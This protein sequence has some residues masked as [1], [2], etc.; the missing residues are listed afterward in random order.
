MR[1]DV[2][3]LANETHTKLTIHRDPL[4]R[5]EWRMLACMRILV[6]EDDTATAHDI[7]AAISQARH[8]ALAV[9]SAEHARMLINTEPF[10]LAVVD[11]GLPGMNGFGLV[12]QLRRDKH[13]LPVLILTGRSGLDDRVNALDIGA[14]DYLTK[15]FEPRELVARCNALLRRAHGRSSNR[16]EVG[17]LR[18]D[19][20]SGQ[21]RIDD[22]DAD[23]SRNER[24]V[25]EKLCAMAG[26]VVE[27]N[28]L[29]ALLAGDGDDPSPH[30]V[31][32]CISRLRVKL[33]GGISIRALRGIGYRLDEVAS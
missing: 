3:T 16:L 33:G 25:L 32:A 4:R 13:D 30:A 12:R 7:T 2:A 27:K 9:A 20:R 28:E 10:D 19:L 31:E 8:S 24:I 18:I 22:R 5:L 14:D 21:V 11:I 23:V 1:N 26:S 29:A 6:V 15:P 17:R